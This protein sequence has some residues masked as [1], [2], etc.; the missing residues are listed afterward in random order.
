MSVL[1]LAI[2]CFTDDFAGIQ[3]ILTEEGTSFCRCERE[4]ACVC[5]CACVMMREI[6]SE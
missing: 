2:G 1:R 5:V 4:C 6:E 3:K